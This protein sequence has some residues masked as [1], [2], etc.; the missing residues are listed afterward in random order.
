M[1]TSE[2]QQLWVPIS[3][4]D[5]K[6]DPSKNMWEL[7]DVMSFSMDGTS[8]EVILKE[9]RITVKV[10]S[11]HVHDPSH[12]KDY[13]DV[14]KMADLHEAPLLK[15]LGRRHA[16]DA[17]YTWSGEIL[18]S[19]NPYR[20]IPGL[21]DPAKVRAALQ[22]QSV[23]HYVASSGQ[24]SS[25]LVNG[26]ARDD[27]PLPPHI[28]SVADLAYK[29]V[30]GTSKQALVVN[31]ESGAGKT[32]ACRQL[33]RYI[34]FASSDT[35][36]GVSRSRAA[37]AA[38]LPEAAAAEAAAAVADP[39]EVTL[40]MDVGGPG[41]P[42]QSVAEEPKSPGSPAGQLSVSQVEHYMLQ[43]SPVLEAFGNAKTIRNVNSSRFGKFTWLLFSS[44]ATLQ[45]SRIET[46][47]L[48][49]A[50]LTQQSV[51]ERNFHIFYS[52]A[53]A[54][55]GGGAPDGAPAQMLPPE[56]YSLL[57]GG[58]TTT[59][60]GV[61]DAT[62]FK[63]T[64]E[65]MATLGFGAEVRAQ[66]WRMLAGLLT[67]GNVRFA[68]KGGEGAGCAPTKEATLE[69]AA[70]L[71]GCEG[72][73]LRRALI[74][75]TYEVHAQATKTTILMSAVDAAESRDALVKHTY[76][77][78]FL[79]LVARINA[80]AAPKPKEAAPPTSLTTPRG[81]RASFSNLF[82][83]MRR[84]SRS[85]KGDSRESGLDGAPAAAAAAAAP[86]GSPAAAS[87]VAPGGW[88]GPQLGLLDIY[89]FENLEV[90]TLDQLCI[91]FANEI[92]QN[93][94]NERIF[95]LEKR[96][97][98]EE[99]IDITDVEFKDNSGVIE[100]IAGKPRGIFALLEEQGRLGERAT[101]ET[102]K[103][104]L[105]SSH[106][107]KPTDD[108]SK[109]F[110]KPRFG[111]DLFTVNHFA[112]HINYD[113]QGFLS[114]NVDELRTDLQAL[115]SS[116][117]TGLIATIRL[118]L[119]GAEAARAGP[120][121]GSVKGMDS[122]TVKFQGQM[123]HI[124]GILRASEPKYVRCIKP[125]AAQSA[126]LYE[127]GLVQ[128][129]LRY[130]GV[131]ETV[132]IRR[133]G[134]PVRVAFQ[135]IATDFYELLL[136]VN[137]GVVN[138][139]ADDRDS[140]I[141]ILTA[142]LEPS[143]WRAGTTR[144]FMA[145]DAMRILVE[146]QAQLRGGMATKLQAIARKKKAARVTQVKRVEKRIETERVASTTVQAAMRRK[147][148][149]AEADR[150][151]KLKAERLAREA[152][153]RK[154]N[155][156]ATVV[157]SRARGLMARNERARR[158]AERINAATKMQSAA[159][160]KEARDE[161]A[162]RQRVVD[163]NNAATK[164]QAAARAKEARGERARRQRVVDENNA[165]T[166]M[167][168]AARAK[169]ARDERAKRQ[170]VV[171][172]REAALTIQR[173]VR[174][175]LTRRLW[176]KIMQATIQAQAAAKGLAMRERFQ[177]M[178][179][180]RKPYKKFLKPN[181][182]VLLAGVVKRL[183]M[184]FL[185]LGFGQKGR[186]QLIFTSF[187]RLLCFDQDVTAIEWEMRWSP[188][189]EVKLGKEGSKEFGISDG[190]KNNARFVDVLGDAVRWK[191][192][193]EA[194]TKGLTGGSMVFEVAADESHKPES[195]LRHQGY[196]IKRSINDPKAHWQR[197]W[198]T[199]Q[200]RT[201]YWFHG[202]D[203]LKGQLELTEGTTVE[204]YDG[205]DLKDRGARTAKAREKA[206]EEHPFSF[207]VQTPEH[208]RV[209]L[210]GLI[211]QA[212]DDED[213]LEWKQAICE[214]IPGMAANAAGKLERSPVLKSAELQ[215]WLKKRQVHGTTTRWQRRWCAFH[216]GTVYWFSGYYK[217][218]GNL[219][220]TPGTVLDAPYHVKQHTKP[221][222]FSIAT[223]EMQRGGVCLTLQAADEEAYKRWTSEIRAAL[224][225]L[226]SPD[227]ARTMTIRHKPGGSQA[228]T[229]RGSDG[230]IKVS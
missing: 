151:A 137:K 149:K 86:A 206:V 50:R 119:L 166:K 63:E 144:M 193:L 178:L 212:D 191:T 80:R 79:W 175:H 131:M 227:A 117:V 99:E 29:Q 220:L 113:P 124:M 75:R 44:G 62:A 143:K 145:D 21:Y 90:N 101:S 176:G 66:V 187:P 111:T 164:M 172:E 59:V 58:G 219:V 34:A 184:G 89:G 142:H 84:N 163:E 69:S 54:A 10:K 156:A 53:A 140:A 83:G 82:K 102:F 147:S 115:L 51:G 127:E 134:F 43:A 56:E 230:G 48:E 189:I 30:R 186:H 139:T 94:F 202:A 224:E 170:R 81:K 28:F 70:A 1:T 155:A 152:Q 100:L 103:A 92:L 38:Q 9:N 125:N 204:D 41:T 146:K 109:N 161:R 25:E 129:Q 60:D 196:L 2:Q 169:E 23:E 42:R 210:P 130:L 93:Q 4:Y 96:M 200:G 116:H 148:A 126:A 19:I 198:I 122:L 110:G 16:R 17:I 49:K 218:K 33:M 177:L 36:R 40:D 105:Y 222:Q 3:E 221:H 132:R 228:L 106:L 37:S 76:E 32:E 97:Y 24:A 180:L 35:K 47:L 11:C 205:Q 136:A 168:A 31:G 185:G 123:K 91:N 217:I 22:R 201:I 20:A 55:C 208:K 12:D 150:L 65:A 68:D 95:V 85:S 153:E 213:R 165:A 5:K 179:R 108:A 173:Y 192:E 225:A 203:K 162:R 157:E 159:R 73:Q 209:E 211:M 216:Q 72:A 77:L 8:A 14:G 46:M 18:L 199:L 15:L 57:S 195:V 215:G 61:D 78:L 135:Q 121:R 64:C 190:T 87:S 114:K 26:E 194:H 182:M 45:G 104:M 174:G 88:D 27:G 52:L 39:D 67:L 71:L 98:E 7:V 107:D 229:P 223:P 226:P 158:I 120:R 171:D 214:S 118:E 141:Q 154:E 197:R 160:A 188:A 112:G 167:Q 181:E 133:T 6:P 207:V 128:Q 138:P 183:D 13:E 74:E